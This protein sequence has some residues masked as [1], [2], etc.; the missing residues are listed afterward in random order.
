MKEKIQ[1]R[2]PNAVCNQRKI[3]T[4]TYSQENKKHGKNK[5]LNRPSI[6]RTNKR[7]TLEKRHLIQ[8]EGVERIS[9]ENAI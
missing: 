8:K 3:K 7:H 1:P 2:I 9:K 6:E 5:S 4:K